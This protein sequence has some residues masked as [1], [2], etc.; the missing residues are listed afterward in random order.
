MR[1]TYLLG[2]AVPVMRPVGQ[3]E[4]TKNLSPLFQMIVPSP[5]KKTCQIFD[6]TLVETFG[7]LKR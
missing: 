5:V 2:F 3:A 7:R 4:N 1:R 6:N